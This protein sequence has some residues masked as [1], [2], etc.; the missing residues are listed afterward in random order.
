MA[1][2]GVKNTAVFFRGIKIPDTKAAIIT[3]HQGKNKDKIIAKKT[4]IIKL[5]VF[6][7]IFS[8]VLKSVC[9]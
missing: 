9:L 4:V 8:W 5:V 7:L 1:K 6:F 3:D 2:K